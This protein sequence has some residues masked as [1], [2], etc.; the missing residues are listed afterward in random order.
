MHL[1]PQ[2]HLDLIFWKLKK[3]KSL[4]VASLLSLHLNSLWEYSLSIDNL[5]TSGD[6]L[7]GSRFFGQCVIHLGEREKSGRS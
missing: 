1:R 2:N 5:Q 4:W 6:C 3:K 7:C